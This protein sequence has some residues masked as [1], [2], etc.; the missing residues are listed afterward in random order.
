MQDIKHLQACDSYRCSNNIPLPIPF[1][2][3]RHPLN[4][5]PF[6]MAGVTANS[7]NFLPQSIH[8]EFVQG[9]YQ[10]EMTESLLFL[11]LSDYLCLDTAQD[12]LTLPNSSSLPGWH[13]SLPLWF[14]K[15]IQNSSLQNSLSCLSQEGFL[16]EQWQGN[17]FCL[18]FSL[19]FLSY[20]H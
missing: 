5:L 16:M 18:S 11:V 1:L 15:L 12:P 19:A 8:V 13:V 10:Q 20:W 17:C 2:A 3:V 6:W 7:A 9:F 14:W 4:I